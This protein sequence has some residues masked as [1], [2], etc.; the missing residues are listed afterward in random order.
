M[1]DMMIA[2]SNG[3]VSPLTPGQA[4][5][6]PTDLSPRSSGSSSLLSDSPSP[7]SAKD[8]T[9][10]HQLLQALQR[11]GVE[12]LSP[13]QRLQFAIERNSLFSNLFN[14][15]GGLDEGR[16]RAE[17][18]SPNHGIKE[19]QLSTVQSQSPVVSVSAKKN[20][21]VTP[22]EPTYVPSPVGSP[23]SDPANIFQCPLCSIVCNGRHSFNEHLV[24]GFPRD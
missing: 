1:F 16:T 13:L 12:D 20:R 2:Q 11:N 24:S 6:H 9:H 4:H 3:G 8:L 19:E 22:V 5:L 14:G 21:A 23:N 17:L 10:H 15:G 7:T 18:S